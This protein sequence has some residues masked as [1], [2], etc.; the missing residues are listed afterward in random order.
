ML[1]LD[2]YKDLINLP[3]DALI[4]IYTLQ[5]KDGIEAA[6]ERGFFKGEPGAIEEQWFLPAYRWMQAQMAAR[7]PDFSGDLPVW[8]WAKRPIVRRKRN[9]DQ[10]E[11]RTRITALVPRRRIL[12]SCFHDWH[13]CLNNSP[14]IQSNAEWDAYERAYPLHNM[15]AAQKRDHQ[16]YIK[17]TWDKVFDLHNPREQEA[18]EWRGANQ[19][20]TPQLCI[21]RLYLDEVIATRSYS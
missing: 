2:R 10:R 11:T 4:R 9:P 8:A 7:L 16:T 19:T 21:D 5:D 13:S 20:V 18:S 1:P 17:S 6:Q 14:V 3:P 15:S 12:F